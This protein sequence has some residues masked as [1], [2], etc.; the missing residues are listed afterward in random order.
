MEYNAPPDDENMHVNALTYEF[1]FVSKGFVLSCDGN[2]RWYVRAAG[3]GILCF[4][5]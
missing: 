1:A 5:C 3:T 4:A 2:V